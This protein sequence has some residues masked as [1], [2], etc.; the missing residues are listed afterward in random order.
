MRGSQ[1]HCYCRDLAHGVLKKQVC[2]SR[3]RRMP[4]AGLHREGV[5]TEGHEVLGWV[6]GLYFN[7]NAIIHIL[8]IHGNI[9]EMSQFY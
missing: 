5:S 7:M 8:K 4:W 2:K 6:L 9:E 1:M 3:K